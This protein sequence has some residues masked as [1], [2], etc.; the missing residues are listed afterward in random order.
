VTPLPLFFAFYYPH[1]PKI[2]KRI[3]LRFLDIEHAVVRFAYFWSPCITRHLTFLPQERAAV[4]NL[5]QE[6]VACCGGG[7]RE[8][9]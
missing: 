4:C 6:F 9:L 5:S 1:Y 7:Q 2:N 8:W 3:F